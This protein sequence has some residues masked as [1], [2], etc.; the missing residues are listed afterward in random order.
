MKIQLKKHKDGWR[1]QIIAANG[2]NIGGMTGESVKNRIDCLH[3][4]FRI[5]ADAANATIEYPEEP[6]L[7]TSVVIDFA[8]WKAANAGSDDEGMQSDSGV[9]DIEQ[10][11]P[12]DTI[13]VAERENW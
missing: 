6:Q 4:V 10:A 9:N 8:R 1:Y 5:Q 11:E 7:N 3:T 2:E 12:S 13:D